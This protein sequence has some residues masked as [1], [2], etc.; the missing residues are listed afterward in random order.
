MDEQKL[1]G[2]VMPQGPPDIKLAGLQIWVHGLEFPDADDYWDGNW[3]N[4][5]AIC[6]AEGASVGLSGNF[7]HLPEI[8]RFLEETETLY[9]NLEGEA[10]L[11]CMELV[12]WVSLKALTMG[13]IA[14][15]VDISPDYST[16]EH[17]FKFQIDQS[18]LPALILGCKNILAKYPVK[19]KERHFL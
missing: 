7:I 16:Q 6:R 5:T 18:Y 4:I 3:L 12:L 1:T 9:K 8:E 11:Y 2:Y 15:S 14:M 13:Q 10:G 17:R 19:D